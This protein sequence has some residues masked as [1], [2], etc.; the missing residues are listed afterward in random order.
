MNVHNLFHFTH[1][2][3]FVC[4]VVVVSLCYVEPYS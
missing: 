4:R 2:S 1:T 3:L